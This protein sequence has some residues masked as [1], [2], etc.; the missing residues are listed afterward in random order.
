MTSRALR[1][2]ATTSAIAAIA[3]I[4]LASTAFAGQT[5]IVAETFTNSTTTSSAWVLPT[6]PVGVN[7]ACLTASGDTSQTPIPGCGLGTPD[8]DGSGALQLTNAN[9]SE[10]GGVAF[11][12]TLPTTR[13]LDVSFDTY[14]Y[15]GN[16][17]DG[18]GFFLAATNP[19]APGPPTNIG[20]P[21]GDLGYASGGGTGLADA[22]LGI[23]I[24]VY[25]NYANGLLD[26]SGCTDPSWVVF[27]STIPGQVTVRGPGNG[28]VGYCLLTSTAATDGGAPQ[29]LDGGGGGTR[30]ISL[31]PVEIVINPSAAPV[32]TTSG[33]TVPAHDYEVAFT[34]L[35]G[36]LQSFTDVLPTTANGEI[37]AG[38]IPAAW[39]NPANGL[40]YQ[41]SMG[42]V[43]STG[44]LVDIHEVSNVTADTLSGALPGLTATLS[45]HTAPVGATSTYL[46]HVATS[47]SGGPEKQDIVVTD[48]F[49]SS[50][51]PLLAG[52]GGVGWTCAL[53]GQTETATYAV[54]SVA[55]G[56]A[57]PVLS[58]PVVV[59][60][61]AGTT[62]VDSASAGSND[63][64]PVLASATFVVPG[65]V[66]IPPTGAAP[67]PD[68][69]VP[70][71]TL[72]LA[73]GIVVGAGIRRRRRQS[74]S[75]RRL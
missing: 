48:T 27:G 24:D 55:P 44:G 31:V 66:P 33:L 30:S 7:S 75:A 15:G 16:G 56:T 37:P 62:V 11:G 39:I 8:P 72:I 45:A 57:L 73:G 35:G 28:T 21:G 67:S 29:N 74:P 43:G 14:Q 19:T 64:F 3:A 68:G 59:I 50:V 13:G 38:T 17:A 22:Y 32:T 65:A 23:G 2:G 61:P 60:G 34:P 69:S 4:A 25:G 52:C 54:T 10:E 18:I 40:P 6:A 12:Q 5:P 58:M 42:W 9:N 49:P 41:L 26:G 53:N 71:G 51:T 36:S 63:V 70:G 1:C 47:A 20:Q 46:V